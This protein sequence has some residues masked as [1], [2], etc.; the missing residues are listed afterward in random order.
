MT[1]LDLRDLRLS[2]WW[3]FISPYRW[4]QHDHPNCWYP[5]TSLHGVHNSEDHDLNL[6]FVAVELRLENSHVTTKVSGI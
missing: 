2:L 4:K 3:R 1:N 5:A 6:Y